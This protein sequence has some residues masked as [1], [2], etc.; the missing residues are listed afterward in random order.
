[1][2]TLVILKISYLLDNFESIDRIKVVIDRNRDSHNYFI[3]V[4]PNTK[5]LSREELQESLAGYFE[6]LPVQF[7]ITKGEG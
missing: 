5:Y 3:I 7:S 1:M 4:Y 2:N 6:G